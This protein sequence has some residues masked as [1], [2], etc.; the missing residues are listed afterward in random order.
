MQPKN[1][2][3]IDQLVEGYTPAKIENERNIEVVGADSIGAALKKYQHLLTI[4]DYFERKEVAQILKETTPELFTSEEINTLLP[5]TAEFQDYLGYS[6]YTAMFI[7]QLLKNSYQQGNTQFNLEVRN[8][9]ALEG[10]GHSLIGTEE[11]PISLTIHGDVGNYCGKYAQH[12]NFNLNGNAG[13][14]CGES[15][16]YACFNIEESTENS[17]GEQSRHSIFKIKK[18][19]GKYLGKASVDGKFLVEGKAGESVGCDSKKSFFYV[20]GEMER[21]S[22]LIGGRADNSTFKTPNPKT[23]KNLRDGLGRGENKFI[24]ILYGKE[25]VLE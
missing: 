3:G 21:N 11:K 12:S 20:V 13:D 4:I 14:Y 10:L 9:P 8:L 15:A 19:T 25:I 1:E 2:T 17:C 5:G 16:Q 22:D 6:W 7:N 23:L 24:F 18:D